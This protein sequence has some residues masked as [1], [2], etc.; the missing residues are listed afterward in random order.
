MAK[1]QNPDDQEGA[2]N[3]DERGH[4]LG[5]IVHGLLWL[6]VTGYWLLV[7]GHWSLVTD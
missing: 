5:S 6:L 1:N 2:E 3:A 7:T 4:L